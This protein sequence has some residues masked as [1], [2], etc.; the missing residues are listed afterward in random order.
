MGHKS[1]NINFD[2]NSATGKKCNSLEE[3]R[4]WN[5]FALEFLKKKS[6]ISTL[7]SLPKRNGMLKSWKK[8]VIL[9]HFTYLKSISIV[10]KISSKKGFK[11]LTL[12]PSKKYSY[13]TKGFCRKIQISFYKIRKKLQLTKRDWIGI[14]SWVIHR[15]Q[16]ILHCVAIRSIGTGT[17][18]NGVSSRLRSH[19]EC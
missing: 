16:Y 18:R 9:L 12:T 4:F 1:I 11:N 2:G 8:E 6:A 3:I 7:F 10:A 19:R 14:P 17:T 5:I 15:P 13:F